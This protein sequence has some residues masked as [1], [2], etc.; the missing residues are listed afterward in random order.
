MNIWVKVL[1]EFEYYGT[2]H[3][4]ECIK[5]ASTNVNQLI[6]KGFIEIVSNNM[7]NNK[8]FDEL[9]EAFTEDNYITREEIDN[10]CNFCRYQFNKNYEYKCPCCGE[11][12][13]IK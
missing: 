5:I 6:S 12:I 11:L 4:G 3:A 8:P 13:K 10:K 2:H 7:G 1:K 9:L